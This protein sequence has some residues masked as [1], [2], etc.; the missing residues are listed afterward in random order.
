[1]FF[2]HGG[3]V[4]WFVAVKQAGHS[5][6]EVGIAFASVK[7]KSPLARQPELLL[8]PFSFSVGAQASKEWGNSTMHC[9][10]AALAVVEPVGVHG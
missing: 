8:D 9:H 1:M 4:G 3:Y 7:C 10:K 6:C 2:P 5:C